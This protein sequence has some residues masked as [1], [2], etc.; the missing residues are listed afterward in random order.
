VRNLLWRRRSP[1]GRCLEI[2]LTRFT[3]RD[4]I[5]E[6]LA[7]LSQRPARTALTM[8]GTVL[9]VGSFVAVLG[10]TA[11]AS[12]QISS[13][14][15]VLTATQ[16]TINDAGAANSQQSTAFNFPADAD[17]T[18]KTLN[19]VVAAGVTW[20]VGG[21]Q[22]PVT[23]NLAPSAV[24]VQMAV[25][26]A[27]PGYLHAIEPQLDQG[28]L[29]NEFHETHTMAVAV[30]GAGVARQLGITTVAQRPAVFVQGHAFTV[31][32]ILARSQRDPAAANSV[33]IP[34]STARQDFGAPLS[35]AAATMLVQTQLGAADLIA[36]QAA[37]ALRPDNPTILQAV[38][39]PRATA[40]RDNVLGSLNSLFVVL[41]AITLIIG[42]VGIANTTLVAVMERTSEIGLRR[43]IG[44]RRRHIAAQFLSESAAIG[45][46]GGLIG[47]AIAICIIVIVALARHWTAVIDPTLTLPA[48]LI[49]TI[50]GL[51]AGAYPALRAAQIEPLE[52][53]RR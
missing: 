10:L 17:A 41:A 11:T 15:S 32:G 49:G 47:T 2:R 42:A 26:A 25:T 27:T 44:A 33:Y 9:G 18:M 50:T 24:P 36:R 38:T 4:L 13:A 29:F 7:G 39:P 8:L 23:A 40:L 19:G 45:T 5:S 12:G 48:P 31:V 28:A 21:G 6:S 20:P 34:A 22:L 14:F 43:A 53:L 51:V 46:L 16:V 3:V 35:Y 30:I 37:L 1:D 52:A